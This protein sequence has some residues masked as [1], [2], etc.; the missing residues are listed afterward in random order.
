MFVVKDKI[1][2]MTKRFPIIG[3]LASMQGLYR[4]TGVPEV[5]GG[6]VRDIWDFRARYAGTMST[7]LRRFRDSTGRLPTQKEQIMVS[8]WLDGLH[9]PLRGW[10]GRDGVVTIGKGTSRAVVPGVGA[11][12]PG[13]EAKMGAPVRRLAQD[14]RV[15]LDTM[16]DESFGTIEKRKQV[17]RAIQEMEKKGVVDEM[18]SSMK[19]YVKNPKKIDRYFPHRIVQSEEDFRL[20]MEEMTSKA[21]TRGYA[22]RAAR[23]TTRWVSPEAQKRKFGMNPSIPELKQLG[24]ELVDFQELAKME[25]IIKYR[26]L[27]RAR[28]EGV[29]IAE[30]TLRKFDGLSLGQIQEHYPKL[31]NAREAQIFAGVLSTARPTPYSLKLLPVMSSY[32]HSSGS[33]YGW[34]IREGGV[35]LMEQVHTLKALAAQRGVGSANAAMRAEMLENTYIPMALGRGTYKGALRAQ[36]WDQSL[37]Q[38]AGWV[39]SPKV[40]KILGKSLTDTFAKQLIAS[41]GSFSYISLSQ[42]AAGWFYLSTLGMNPASALKNLLQLVLTTGPVLGPRTTIAGINQAM[43]NSH[44]Y[45]AV[46]LGPRKLTHDAAIRFAWPAYGRSGIAAAPIT[47]EVLNNSFQNAHNIAALPTGK[48]ASTSRKIQAAMM[49]MFTASETAVRLSTWEAALIHARRARLPAADAQKFA[50]RVVEET[51]F[52]TGPQNTPYFLVDKNPLVRQ[53][54][55]FPLRML[56]FATHTAWN[57][58]TTAINPKT[59]KAMNLLGKNPGTFARMIA[60]SVLA[61]EL[62]QA[63][64]VDPSDALLGG[65]LPTFQ[66]GREGAFGGFPVI[67][68]SFQIAGN[69]ASGL[70]SGD[71]TEMMRTTP[72]LIPGGVE[73]FR[74]M[75]LVPGVPHELGQRAAKL[76]GRTYADYDQ[77]APDGRIALYSGKGSLKGYFTPWEIVRHGLGIR[78]GDMQSEQEL[79]TLLVKNRDTI[80]ET[81]KDY[82]DARLRNDASGALSISQR[83]EQQFG[84]QLPVTE[85]DMEAMQVRR[86]VTRLEQLVRTMPPG[87]LRD[88]Y[89]QLIASTL[90]ASGEALLGIDP[91]LL[92]EP[93]PARESARQPTAPQRAANPRG[94]YGTGPFDQVNPKTVGRQPLPPTSRFGF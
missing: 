34:T 44:K 33:M 42:R 59:G 76:F 82:L 8:A 85:K 68:P 39:K 72:L 47:D 77:P 80:R 74:A 66:E 67:P 27:A 31:M 84:F 14:F 10:K 56:E 46:R 53:L 58:G 15:T 40:E 23:K 48:L 79:M 51:Q 17:Y 62:G 92:S 93:K 41:H 36:S 20:I 94:P 81:R 38:L 37:Y 5:Y 29:G 49:S 88:R 83:F 90:G 65:A 45:F 16:W 43:K 13:L 24:P 69:V 89:I 50:A 86:R 87:P 64:G 35:K 21:G 22:A 75:G 54:A 55:Q 11:L 71:F 57:L 6:I 73:A 91:M 25:E 1:A 32:A 19:E 70:A 60:G 63:L 30:Q 28:V 61:M 12:M 52:L 18:T 9:E 7:S 78:S 26:T 2:A 4:G 3:K